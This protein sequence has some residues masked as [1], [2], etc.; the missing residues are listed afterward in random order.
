MEFQGIQYRTAD[1]WFPHVPVAELGQRPI[2]YLEIGALHG[3]NLLSVA[4]TYAAHP[5]SE[6]HAI[7][8]WVDYAEYPEAYEQATGYETFMA[9]VARSGYQH[10]IRVH[11]GFSH[12][13]QARLEDNSFDLIY[14]DGNH[15]PEYVL[16]DA[17]LAFRKLKVGGY[18][19]FDDVGW[20][21]PDEVSKGIHA[22]CDGYHKRIRKIAET[23]QAWVQKI[24]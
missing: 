22:F 1:N 24:K 5:E 16:E 8:P 18:L 2:K 21:G 12:V 20:G 10:K 15:E 7:D 3:A 19:V 6:L 23:D 14:I 9:N 13:E 4:R 11:R 17:V